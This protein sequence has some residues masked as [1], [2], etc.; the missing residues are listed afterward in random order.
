MHSQDDLEAPRQQLAHQI[1]VQSSMPARISTV[2]EAFRL[3]SKAG[4][5]AILM[6]YAQAKVTA[7]GHADT[8]LALL[9][10]ATPA[11]IYQRYPAAPSLRELM[12]LARQ[13]EG[14]LI[15]AYARYKV[16]HDIAVA[17][18]GFL[19]R[20]LA[21]L[22]LNPNNVLLC[23]IWDGRC[24]RLGLIIIDWANTAY[25]PSLATRDSSIHPDYETK[26]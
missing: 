1:S 8:A 22:D 13:F 18:R 3:T 11:D 12:G 25:H 17:L 16:V 24:V 5:R 9:P 20:G 21:H 2:F 7:D 23:Q 26:G 15:T 19:S 4:T 10:I 6:E 14:P